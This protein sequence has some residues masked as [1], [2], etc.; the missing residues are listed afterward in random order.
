MGQKILT[1]YLLGL[2]KEV[3]ICF[4]SYGIYKGVRTVENIV[5]YMAQN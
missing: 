1:G 2:C 5:S 4:I 3:V